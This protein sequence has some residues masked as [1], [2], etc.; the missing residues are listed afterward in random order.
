MNYP[1]ITIDIQPEFNA[2]IDTIED[3][4]LDYIKKM[5]NHNNKI[6]LLSWID[7]THNELPYNLLINFKGRLI[8]SIGN[9]REI[10]CKK[11]I[12]ELNSKYK[13]LKEYYCN[14]PWGSIEEI[15]IYY[16]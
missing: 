15:K 16:K 3:N 7:Y 13:L 6:L 14:M 5:E 4:G 8:I 9:Y 11:Y 12:D 1:V 2:W 10:D